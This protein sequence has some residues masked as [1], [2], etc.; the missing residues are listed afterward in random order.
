MKHSLL[1]VAF[2]VLCASASLTAA[3]DPAQDPVKEPAPHV[4]PD[5]KDCIDCHGTLVEGRVLHEPV[6]EEMCDACHGQPDESLHVFEMPDNQSDTCF[7]CHDSVPGAVQHEPVMKGHC[8]AC[9]EP[10]HS[11][12]KALLRTDDDSEMCASC[13]EDYPGLEEE[14][15]HGPVDAGMCTICHAPHASEEPKLLIEEPLTLCLSCHEDMEEE[16]DEAE[17][18]HLP[19]EE[20][21]GLCHD[22]H[23][24][25]N[26]FQLL[27][28]GALLC[29][30]CHDGIREST[31]KSVDHAAVK[32]EKACLNCHQPHHSAFPA[33]LNASPQDMC[34]SCHDAAIEVDEETT[35]TAMG[36]LL[37]LDFTHGPIQEGNCSA[38]HDPHGSDVFSILRDPYPRKFYSKW[39]PG[40]YSLCFR[41]HEES[42]FTDEKTETLT[43]FRDGDINLHFLHVNRAKKGRTCRACHEVHA[44]TLPVHLAEEVPFGAWNM[45]INFEV[46]PDGGSCSPGCHEPEAY[47]RNGSPEPPA[48]VERELPEKAVEETPSETSSK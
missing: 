16:M 26:E 9:H 47:N 33:M 42:I 4:L 13:H 32:D 39:D 25:P 28:P 21:C 18:V 45:P 2:I 3:Q 12:F 43:D 36:P 35:I 15:I 24:G 31:E 14:F 46:Q 8:T 5:D 27:Q 22:P 29:F 1:F 23:S 38:C 44:S 48:A 19:A 11:E 7:T 6:E 20:D 41:C 37:K 10:H 17:N 34:M 30:D 40:M